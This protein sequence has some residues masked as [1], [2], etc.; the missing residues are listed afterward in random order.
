[1]GFG[2]FVTV[3]M[4]FAAVLAWQMGGLSAATLAQLR[5][6]AWILTFCFAA[7]TVLSWRYFFTVAIV[8]SAAVTLV[9]GAA[10]YVSGKQLQVG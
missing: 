7:N 9:L 2:L 10:A 8:L 5:G 6:I 4:V 3:F 1:M